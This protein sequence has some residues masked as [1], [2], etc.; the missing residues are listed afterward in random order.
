MPQLQQLV[1]CDMTSGSIPSQTPHVGDHAS[2]AESSDP[3]IKDL[4]V[5]RF[6]VGPKLKQQLLAS[7]PDEPP[8]GAAVVQVNLRLALGC[9][10]ACDDHRVRRELTHTR[11]FESSSARAHTHARTNTQMHTHTHT[12]LRAAGR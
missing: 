4:D 1:D 6:I 5:S 9:V 3:Q 7:V 10:K 11:R 2:P 8:A 12:G